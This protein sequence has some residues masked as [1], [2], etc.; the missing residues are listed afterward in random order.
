MIFFEEFGVGGFLF[1]VLDFQAEV[2]KSF[3]RNFA[4]SFCSSD[5]AD[6]QQVRFDDIFEGVTLLSESSGKGIDAGRPAF[7]DFGD[8]FE[9][10]SV[11]GVKTHGVNLFHLEGVFDDFFVEFSGTFNLGVVPDALEQAVCNSWCAAGAGGDKVEC[12]VVTRQIEQLCRAFQNVSEL[13]GGVKVE[14]IKDA[15]SRAQRRA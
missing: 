6:L 9:E 7:I 3:L 5:K 13:I 14:V 2:V 12:V 15:E 4:S 1:F 8:G 11:E 10:G